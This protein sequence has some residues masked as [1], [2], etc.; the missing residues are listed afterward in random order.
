MADQGSQKRR[1]RLGRGL[2]ALMGQS[3]AV[4]PVHGTTLETT[5][6]APAAT[7]SDDEPQALAVTENAGSNPVTLHHL[8]I[9]EIQPNRHQPRT[10]FQESS[11]AS[12]SA[13]IKSAGVMQPILVTELS[14]PPGQAR[15]ELVAGERRWRAA[16]HAGL[17]SVPAIVRDLDDSQRAQLALVE[18]LHRED[19]NPIER[20]AAFDRLH[21]TFGMSHDQIA[22]LVGIDRST[23]TNTLRLL[24]LDGQVQQLL[25]DGVV[26]AGQAKALAGLSDAVQQL[27]I[28]RQAVTRQWSVRQVEAAVRKAASNDPASGPQAA[29]QPSRT[30]THIKDLEQKLS[31]QLETRVRIR[32]GRK[33]GTGTMSLDFYS[34]DHFDTLMKRMGVEI[35]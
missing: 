34:L 18:N 14:S 23:V 28:A 15:Y 8:P 29:S 4:D 9:S 21:A 25:I 19:L 5:K 20:A 26:T 2:S 31:Q 6:P 32:P 17:E 10:Q 3:V 1:P 33:K 16:R 27:T 11:I 35:E 24:Q 13:S 12:L 22:Q 7:D 30:P